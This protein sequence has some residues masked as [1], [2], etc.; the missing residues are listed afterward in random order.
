MHVLETIKKLESSKEFSAWKKSH[1]EAY[2]AHAFMMLDEANKD[3]WQIGYFNPKTN[4]I[5]VFVVD[6]KIS[7]N[8]DSEVFK[9]QKKMVTPLIA[10]DVKFNEEQALT[11]A[12]KILDDNYKGNASVKSFMILQDI[13]EI[14]L[15]WNLTFLTQ[16]FKTINIK[17]DATTGECK[18]HKIVSLI[19][20]KE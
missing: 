3:I 14:G 11:E 18:G 15:V 9:E 2:L 20:G 10:R 8:E 17:I 1:K 12:K 13:D 4:L 7:K 6:K 5:S 19:Q 16:Q